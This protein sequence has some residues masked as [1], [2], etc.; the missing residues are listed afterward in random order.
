VL[1][2]SQIWG[3]KKKEKKEEK[4]QVPAVA[5]HYSKDDYITF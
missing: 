5:E 2:V 3:R 4:V 1:W